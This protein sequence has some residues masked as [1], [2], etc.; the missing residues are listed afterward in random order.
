MGQIVYNEDTDERRPAFSIFNAT[1]STVFDPIFAPIEFDVDME[2][3]SGNDRDYS[4]SFSGRKYDFVTLS[5][6]IET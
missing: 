2:A 1:G 6:R 3:R 4:I 5:P